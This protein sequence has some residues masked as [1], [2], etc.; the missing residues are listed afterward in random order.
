LLASPKN[1]LSQKA[2]RIYDYLSQIREATKEE[3]MRDAALTSDDEYLAAKNELVSKELVKPKQGRHGGLALLQAKE[4]G[5]IAK[6]LDQKLIGTPSED[7]GKKK[8][9]LS[10]KAEILW[11]FIPKKGDWITNL[12]LRNSLRPKKF[13]SD[14]FWK[15]R[16]ELLNKD[17]VEIGRGQGGRIRRADSY[18]SEIAGKIK[19]EEVVTTVVDEKELYKHIEEWLRHNEKPRL[20]QEALRENAHARVFVKDTSSMRN[21]GKWSNP[22]IMLVSIVNYNVLKKKAWTIYTYEVKKYDK[23]KMRDP[24]NVFEAASH[25]K[26]AHYSYLVFETVEEDGEESPPEEISDALERFGV[27]FAWFFKL[28]AG[29]YYMNVMKDADLHPVAL[30][31][32]NKYL[33]EFANTL[34]PQERGDFEASF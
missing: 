10:E 12:R 15:H 1:Q 26:G 9:E 18:V 11:G 32:E 19:K 23:N 14:D 6:Y 7:K 4:Q 31:E 22:D 30:G 17:M 21:I 24:A 33:M 34:D 16:K 28:K 2:K 3:I 29:G 25:Q 13:T 5:K 20:E 8:I 27:G